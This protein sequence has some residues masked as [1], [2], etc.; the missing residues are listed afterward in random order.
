[1]SIL[2]FDVP[3]KVRSTADHNRDR[4]SD[5]GIPGTYAPNMSDADKAKWKAK[6]IRGGRERIEIRKTFST[7][8][9]AQVLVRVYRDEVALSAN[10]TVRM[11]SPEYAQLQMAIAEA[12]RLLD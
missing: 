10:G 3:E 2:S 5:L 9:Y 4:W 8:G 11:T 7:L 1:M 6:H 12:T